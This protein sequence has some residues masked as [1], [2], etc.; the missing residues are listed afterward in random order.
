MILGAWRRTWVQARLRALA[1]GF[2]LEGGRFLFFALAR[3]TLRSSREYHAL[4]ANVERKYAIVEP[5]R[6]RF[7]RQGRSRLAEL[8]GAVH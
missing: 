1:S 8:V 5:S 3:Y 7:S 4:L 2:G 6:V